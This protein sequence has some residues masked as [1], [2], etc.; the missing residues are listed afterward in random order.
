[1]KAFQ[2]R[3][4]R[5][6]LLAAVAL[7]AG[8]G[9]ARH[10]PTSAR[11][12]GAL[13]REARPIGRGPRFHP[14]ATGPVLGR[15]QRRLGARLA[16]H[17]EVFGENRVVLLPAGIG[18]RPPRRVSGGR[19]IGARCYAELVTLDSTGVVLARRGRALTLGALFRSWGEPLSPTRLA[20]FPAAR[21]GHVVAFVDGRRQ[22]VAPA[23]VPITEH[24]EIV[25][26]VGPYVPPHDTFAFTPIG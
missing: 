24:A 8:C 25:L 2:V 1:V 9:S 16:A 20:S 22:R 5:V 7:L 26:E 4:A 19:I 6:A 21:G 13:L 17:I 14:P 23:Q 12:P 15:C 10:Q 18:T 11:V 3:G